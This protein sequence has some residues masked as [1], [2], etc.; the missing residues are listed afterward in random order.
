MDRR[1]A[2]AGAADAA[3]LALLLPRVRWL[4]LAASVPN[5]LL[6]LGGIVYAAVLVGGAIRGSPRTPSA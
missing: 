3:A 2:L 1:G 6:F 5:A 4:S